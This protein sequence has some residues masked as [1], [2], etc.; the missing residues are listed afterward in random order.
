MMELKEGFTIIKQSVAFHSPMR[1][2]IPE[3]LPRHAA[4]KLRF[5]AGTI[6]G[7]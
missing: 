6:A 3:F 2:E 1:R 5:M 4:R 7:C